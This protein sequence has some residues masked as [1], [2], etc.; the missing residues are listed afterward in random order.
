[1]KNQ[2]KLNREHIEILNRQVESIERHLEESGYNC[3]PSDNIIISSN[4]SE[5]DR[6]SI[7]DVL[8]KY[9]RDIEKGR[10]PDMSVFEGELKTLMEIDYS[11]VKRI[12]LALSAEGRFAYV[13]REYAK[14]LNTS[15]TRFILENL[16]KN[17]CF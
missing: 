8:D 17:Q 10:I 11:T 3:S 14:W 6:R 1:M 15:E 4:W 5:E 13:C 9:D 7:E 12:I 16:K 2:E